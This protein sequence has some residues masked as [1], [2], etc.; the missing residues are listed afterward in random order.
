MAGCKTCIGK[1]MVVL[2]VLVA[3][4]LFCSTIRIVQSKLPTSR[5]MEARYIA[6]LG[7]NWHSLVRIITFQ[8]STHGMKC[9][10][11]VSTCFMAF[12]QISRIL[13]QPSIATSS[14]SNKNFHF[15]QELAFFYS[16]YNFFHFSYYFF[17]KHSS[18][19]IYF[20]YQL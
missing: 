14:F 1:G 12:I 8:L 5:T 18:N 6:V 7:Y 19:N 15:Q 11:Y 10:T 3:L 17:I 16:K 20:S 13:S 9:Q 2:N 4:A